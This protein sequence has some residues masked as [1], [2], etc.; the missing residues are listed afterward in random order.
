MMVK[1]LSYNETHFYSFISPGCNIF[2]TSGASGTCAR[3]VITP[4][5][6]FVVSSAD[7]GSQDNLRDA[8][9]QN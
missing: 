9:T 8:E 1:R 4:W 6:L 2:I 7:E 5:L 3:V